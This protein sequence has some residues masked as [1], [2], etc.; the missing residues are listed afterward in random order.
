MSMFPPL[1]ICFQFTYC[2]P[3]LTAL[4][5]I[6]SHNPLCFKGVEKWLPIPPA[7]SNRDRTGGEE[8]TGGDEST[9]DNF[10]TASRG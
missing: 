1:S 8:H 7:L 2:K 9:V 4:S 5:G 3:G 10:P 6:C